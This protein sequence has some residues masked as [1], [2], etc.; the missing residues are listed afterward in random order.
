MSTSGSERTD[1]AVLNLLRA[2]IAMWGLDATVARLQ[3]GTIAIG[4]AGGEL[5]IGRAPP[6]LPFRWLVAIEGRQ[7]A[8]SSVTG[9]LRVV[10]STLDPTWRPGRARIATLPPVAP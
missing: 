4:H 8:A 1:A 2:S 7:R 10:R 6:A 3:D 9:L 5:R